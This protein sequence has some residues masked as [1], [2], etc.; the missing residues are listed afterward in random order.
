MA[1]ANLISLFEPTSLVLKTTFVA[2][3]R[4]QVTFTAFIEPSGSAAHAPGSAGAA[5][6]VVGSRK[7]LSLYNLLTL[8][9][10]WSVSGVF[11]AF[12]TASS[13]SLVFRKAGRRSSDS[14]AGSA[15]AAHELG[16]WIAVC[17]SVSSDGDSNRPQQLEQ[18]VSA[19][20]TGSKKSSSRKPSA[21]EDDESDEEG[22]DVSSA[23]AKHEVGLGH[24]RISP[25]I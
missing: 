2:A 21:V 22:A 19:K 17:N 24:L 8:E 13:D 11:S 10:V 16:G 12:N 20:D 4:Q 1:H 15:A 25:S 18:K 6:L 9:L 14:S 23:H 5:Y 3:A 7:L